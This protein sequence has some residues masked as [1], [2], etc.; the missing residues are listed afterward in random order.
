MKILALFFLVTSL[1]AHASELEKYFNEADWK[2]IYDKKGYIVHSQKAKNSKVVG[3][4]AQ[5]VLNTKIEKVLSVLRD[6][7]GTTRWAPNM[8]EKKTIVEYSDVKAI[9]YNNNDLPWPVAD[10][11]MVLM[12]ELRVDRENRVL[13]VDTHS[14]THPDYPPMKKTVRSLMPYGTLEFKRFEGKSWVRMTILVEPK[15]SIPI[16]IVNM[17]QKR[18]PIQFLKALEKECGV[19]NVPLLPGIK[20]LLDELDSL[21]N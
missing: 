16:W 20:K 3:F 1:N 12:N 19:S 5:A 4:R 8:V 15:G 14:V 10:R 11:D 9:T 2:K 17:I 21:S 7:E 6:V 18:F 13:V